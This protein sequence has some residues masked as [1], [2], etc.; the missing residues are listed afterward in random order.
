MSDYQIEWPSF[1]QKVQRRRKTKTKSSKSFFV[2]Y[3][4]RYILIY[5]NIGN[6]ARELANNVSWLDIL[7][8]VNTVV[9]AIRSKVCKTITFFIII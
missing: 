2:N 8:G 4:S 7:E 6:K 3:T 1:D 9:S 5:L